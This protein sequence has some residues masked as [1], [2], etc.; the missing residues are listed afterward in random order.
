M[1]SLILADFEIKDDFRKCLE[2]S[3]WLNDKL[4]GDLPPC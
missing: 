4:L 1:N 3:Y 2:E